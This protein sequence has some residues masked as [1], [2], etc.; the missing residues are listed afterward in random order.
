M[1]STAGA[2]LRSLERQG[3]I[4]TRDR[5]LAI[6]QAAALRQFAGA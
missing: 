4:E 3:W 2:A 5:A 6:N 1:G